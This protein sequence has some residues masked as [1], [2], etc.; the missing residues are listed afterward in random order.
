MP[1]HT[2]SDISKK[3]TMSAPSNHYAAPLLVVGCVVFGLGSLIVKF[4]P[5]GAYAI[6]WWRL[7][8][9]GL[10]FWFLARRFGQKLPRSKT[11]LA[12]A[13]LSGAALGIDLA[14]WHESI[15][16]VGPGIST[17]LNSLQIFLAV[18]GVAMIAFPEFGH[19]GNAVWGFVSGI[20]SGVML[21]LSMTFIRK[22]HQA[23]PTALFP[24]MLLVSIGGVLALLVPT[25]V[26]DWGRLYPATARDIGLV[27]VYGAVMQCFAWGLIAY[28]IPLLSLSLTVLLL[29]S[30][31]V[32]ALLIDYFWLDKPINA[33]QWGGAALTLLAIYLGSLK[34]K[35]H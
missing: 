17:L 13:L 18:G 6:A 32:A 19:N 27:L 1:V 10:V 14:L 3:N 31:P 33:V 8:I 25:L 35:A 34:T 22:T 5:V 29:L 28:A 2:C 20:I 23:E 12:Y 30:E 26:F 9:S 24:M 15:Y 7:L 11:A 21:A 16:S 4:V